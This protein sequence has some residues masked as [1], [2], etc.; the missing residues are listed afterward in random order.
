MSWALPAPGAF[1]LRSDPA[2]A[3]EEHSQ[4]WGHSQPPAWQPALTQFPL[5]YASTVAALCH[6]SSWE[7]V[8]KAQPAWP[9]CRS[10]QSI[11]AHNGRA[12]RKRSF[13]GL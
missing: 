11:V 7:P 10:V 6:P 8:G 4:H 3:G 9:S 12:V 13:P 5:V 1:L 2:Q